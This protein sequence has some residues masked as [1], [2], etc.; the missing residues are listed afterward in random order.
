M[1]IPDL[2][3]NDI[4][5]R[6]AEAIAQ[7]ADA[8]KKIKGAKVTPA[9][10][11]Q[12]PAGN[13]IDGVLDLSDVSAIKA[14]PGAPGALR[15][16]NFPTIGQLRIYRE[17]LNIEAIGRKAGFPAHRLS[18]KVRTASE[19]SIQESRAIGAVLGAAGIV[20]EKK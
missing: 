4:N 1:K 20:L 18:R 8:L 19:L 3:T 15:P 9:G 5:E 12:I 17:L 6:Q 2:I 7:A 14:E 16:D 10:V 11:L 13:A